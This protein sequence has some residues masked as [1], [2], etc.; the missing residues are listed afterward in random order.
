[1]PRS[2]HLRGRDDTEAALAGQVGWRLNG[3]RGRLSGARAPAHDGGHLPYNEEIAMRS[4]RFTLL[5]ASLS[6]AACASTGRMSDSEKLA[7]YSS[8]AGAPVRDIRYVTPMGW[9]KI[10]GQH[11]LLTIRPT[12]VWLLRLS[13]PCL[14]WSGPSPTILLRRLIEG[15][16]SFRSDRI[17]TPDSMVTCRI[18]EI[19]PVDVAAVRASREAMAAN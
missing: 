12:E 14:D 18:D 16:L 8:H 2:P 3:V 15:R 7:F 6:L 9:D 11:L 5:F 10:D 4:L 13:G 17:S 1:M 19:R